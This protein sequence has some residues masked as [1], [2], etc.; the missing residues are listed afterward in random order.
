MESFYVLHV[1]AAEI[2]RHRDGLS[3]MAPMPVA[4]ARLGLFDRST[5]PAPNDYTTTSQVK[6]FGE[7]PQSTPGYL[8]M[9]TQTNDRATQVAAGR[10]YACVQLAAAAHGVSMQPLSQAL[11]AYA[12]QKE[13]YAQSHTLLGANQTG[14]AAQMW[15]RV[16][17]AEP[18]KPS[19]RRRLES[20]VRT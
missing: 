2:A 4:L 15:A 12:E 18:V 11:Q 8:W 14:H 1:G 13:P 20:F 17:Y 9:V 16:D 5:P 10:A 3:L 6:D 19:P 7:K